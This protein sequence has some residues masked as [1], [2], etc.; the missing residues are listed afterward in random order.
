MFIIAAR[1]EFAMRLL[2]NLIA[3]N[4]EVSYLR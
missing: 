3:G 1:T 2:P 4:C